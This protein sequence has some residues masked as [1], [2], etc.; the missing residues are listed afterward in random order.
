[1]AREPVCIGCGQPTGPLPR[2]NRLP[3]G[4]ACPTCQDRLL[5]TLPPL[6]PSQPDQDPAQGWIGEQEEGDEDSPEDYLGGA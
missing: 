4:R 2:L 6:L 1:M 5:A 3:N